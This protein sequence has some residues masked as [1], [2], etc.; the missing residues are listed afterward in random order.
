MSYFADVI[1][2]ELKD[3]ELGVLHAAMLMYESKLMYAYDLSQELRPLVARLRAELEAERER[4]RK[5]D[6]TG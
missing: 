6:V 2:Q 3:D 1:A 5:E 4:R